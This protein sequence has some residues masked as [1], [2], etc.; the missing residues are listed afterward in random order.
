[1][2]IAIDTAHKLTAALEADH[3]T[4][5]ERLGEISQALAKEHRRIEEREKEI[6]ALVRDKAEFS[7]TYVEQAMRDVLAL[8]AIVRDGSD[9]MARAMAELAK[10][11]AQE[12]EVGIHQEAAE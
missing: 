1:M 5:L 9:D 10:P 12:L 6:I 2:R 4:V 11:P 8:T 3:A 7:R